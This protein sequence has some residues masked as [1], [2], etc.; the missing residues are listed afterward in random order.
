MSS[1][2]ALPSDGQGRHVL[3]VLD[4]DGC[5]YRGR[6]MNPH[7]TERSIEDRHLNGWMNWLELPA[8]R[9]AGR[10]PAENYTCHIFGDDARPVL[11]YVSVRPYLLLSGNG[12]RELL[13]IEPKDDSEGRVPPC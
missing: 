1:Q 2:E 13:I 9:I 6:V 3:A 11:D 4:L 8:G 12:D 10:V 7:E 5:T